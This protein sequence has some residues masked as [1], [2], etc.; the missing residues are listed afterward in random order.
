MDDYF[1]GAPL[2]IGNETQLLLD[3]AI[4]EDRWGL[5]RVLQHPAKFSGNPV[6]RRDRPWEG[7]LVQGPAVIRDETFGKYRMWYTCFNRKHFA[8]GGGPSYYIGY[9]ESA[10]GFQWEKPLFDHLP[11][12]GHARTNIVY[13]GTHEQGLPGHKQQRVEMGQVFRDDEDPDPGRRYKMIC[14]EGRPRP[15]L[16]EVHSGIEM[17]V[18]PDGLHWRLSGERSILDQHSDAAN[19]VVYDTIAKLWLLYCRPVVYSSGRSDSRRHHRRRVALMT[20]PDFVNWS[21]PRVVLYPDELDWPDY[22]HALVFRYGSHHLM[23]IGAME[24]DTTGRKEIRIA[25]SADGIRWERFHTRAAFIPQGEPGSDEEGSVLPACPPIRQGEDLLIYYSG[26]RLGQHESGVQSGGC[27][28]A[29]MK[30]D[31]F[32]AQQADENAGWLLT[33]EFIL[34]GNRLRVNLAQDR[35]PYRMPRL[36]VEILRHPPMGGHWGFQEIY[37]GFGLEDCDPLSGDS[38]SLTVTW[39]G[40]PDLSPLRGKA[41]YLRFELAHMSLFAFRIENA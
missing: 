35:R 40:N 7:D 26:H 25:S 22:D 29:T 14:L 37:P 5:K 8:H 32:V 18:S 30:A 39:K 28:V 19:H 2:R 17:A 24:G 13:A 21:Y 20:S 38:T 10:D 31:R 33:R 16:G 12:G 41:V 11:V 23:F 4:V 1:L 36:R 34:G 27:R 3:D 9:A 15:D 6:I